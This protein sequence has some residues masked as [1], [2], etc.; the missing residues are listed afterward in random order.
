MERKSG[1]LSFLPSVSRSLHPSISLSLLGD[2]YRG[3]RVLTSLSHGKGLRQVFNQII[4][5]FDADRE[6]HEIGWR[7]ESVPQRLWDAGVRHPAGQADGRTDR[8]E[9]DRDVEKPSGLNHL[10]R[11]RHVAGREA[12]D[13]AVAGGLIAMDV[14]ARMVGETGIIDLGDFR[15]IR[16]ELGD[17]LSRFVLALDA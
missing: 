2:T 4:Y 14:A 13:G 12:D 7:R 11:K 5:I 10:P 8:T 16:Q 17:L 15:A 9:A 6:A 3:L 1:S